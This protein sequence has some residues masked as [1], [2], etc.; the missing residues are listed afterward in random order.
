[1]VLGRAGEPANFFP[2][3]HMDHI[4]FSQPWIM[5]IEIKNNINSKYFDQNLFPFYVYYKSL[6]V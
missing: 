1:M 5:D 4:L 3:S 2:K 6:N